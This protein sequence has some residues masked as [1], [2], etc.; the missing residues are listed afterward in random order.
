VN[1]ACADSKN[2]GSRSSKDSIPGLYFL[3]MVKLMVLFLRFSSHGSILASVPYPQSWV[4][5]L[6]TT[7]YIF[8]LMSSISCGNDSMKSVE[9]RLFSVIV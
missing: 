3:L 8:T 5:F 7:R 9:T 6:F 1:A 2:V 4:C